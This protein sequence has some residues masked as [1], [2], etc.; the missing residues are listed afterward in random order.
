MAAWQRV[1]LHLMASYSPG[2]NR[3]LSFHQGFVNI[4]QITGN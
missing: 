1:C 3:Q 2:K 4:G